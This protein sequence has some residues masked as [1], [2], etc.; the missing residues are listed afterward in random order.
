[1]NSETNRGQWRQDGYIPFGLTLLSL[2]PITFGGVRLAELAGGTEATDAGRFVTSLL[3]IVTHILAATVYSLG[4]AIQFW[5]TL[6]RRSPRWHRITGYLMVPAGLLTAACA[7][8]I[9][10]FYPRPPDEAPLLAAFRWLFG[11]AIV[12]ALLAGVR[13]LRRREYRHHGA[14]MLRAYALAMEAVTQTL[15]IIP[16]AMLFGMPS[17]TPLALLMGAVWVV[18]FGLAEW[19]IKTGRPR[20]SASHRPR[21]LA[22]NKAF[23]TT[24]GSA[25]A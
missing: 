16:T 23:E 22:V 10:A 21:S 25:D 15:T 5:P 18:N 12:F 9:Q 24:V 8:W 13:S 6:R 19:I 1:M 11:S 20:A 17:K 3:P 7:L 4:G 2:I 14:W